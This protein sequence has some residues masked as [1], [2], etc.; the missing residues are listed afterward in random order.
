MSAGYKRAP[1]GLAA[2][3]PE[4]AV[5]KGRVVAKKRFYMSPELI[6]NIARSSSEGGRIICDK[7]GN[8]FGSGYVKP[9]KLSAF[10]TGNACDDC[11]KKY[12]LTRV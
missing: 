11:R 3:M 12:G 8:G 5:I 1:Q 9:V 10:V 2:N 7:C 4:N 6:R